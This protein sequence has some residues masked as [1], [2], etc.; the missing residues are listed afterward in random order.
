[1][2]KSSEI[3]PRF[4]S[5][6]AF[7]MK[8]N[9]F[10]KNSFNITFILSKMLILIEGNEAG[11]INFLGVLKISDKISLKFIEYLENNKIIK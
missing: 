3:T 1:M 7:P 11:F 9:P 8:S 5:R 6:L 2:S 4:F 10:R